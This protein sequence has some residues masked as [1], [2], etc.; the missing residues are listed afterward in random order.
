[1]RVTR[2]GADFFFLG[3]ICVDIPSAHVFDIIVIYVFPTF[4]GKILKLVILL[5]L[6]GGLVG[7][8]WFG[9]VVVV[10]DGG[11]FRGGIACCCAGHCE[12]LSAD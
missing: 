8:E 12:L 7:L 10:G 3:P 5:E 6:R 2:L 1:M 9:G 11:L 4:Y